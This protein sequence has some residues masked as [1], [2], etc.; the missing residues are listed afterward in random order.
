MRALTRPS[1]PR[2]RPAPTWS[3][4]ATDPPMVASSDAATGTSGRHSPPPDDLR[5]LP[6]PFADGS[7]S[8]AGAPVVSDVSCATWS[9]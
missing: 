2:H 6:F 3:P 9:V 7:G 5:L 1:L 8:G 4:P